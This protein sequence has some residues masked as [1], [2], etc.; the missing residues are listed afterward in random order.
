[1]MTSKF[2]QGSLLV[3]MFFSLNAFATGWACQSYCI[4]IQSESGI[5]D[6]EGNVDVSIG[7]KYANRLNAFHMLND[8]CARLVGSYSTPTLVQDFSFN[9]TEQ[10]D[11]S[12]GWRRIGWAGRGW[13]DNTTVS[14]SVYAKPA[15]MMDAC[16]LDPSIPDTDTPTVDDNF[17]PPGGIG[18]G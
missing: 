14:R 12:W 5:V 4:G 7:V 10:Q 18:G 2:I 16:Q 6:L 3:S 17:V 13:G 15:T 9:V 1:M 11:G 8:S